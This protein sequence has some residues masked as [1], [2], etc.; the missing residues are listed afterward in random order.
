MKYVIHTSCVW[1]NLSIFI[2]RVFSG[3]SWVW[4]LGGLRAALLNLL[5]CCLRERVGKLERKTYFAI[6]QI[7]IHLQSTLLYLS[8]VTQYWHCT[9][10]H[11]LA[12]D[13]KFLDLE[14]SNRHKR[15]SSMSCLVT[16]SLEN[17]LPCGLWDAFLHFCMAAQCWEGKRGGGLTYE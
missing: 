8:S 9:M 12:M 3:L 2:D 17:W 14:I 5:H 15:E 7:Y 4:G 16:F 1:I 11:R 13:Q 10:I 6:Y